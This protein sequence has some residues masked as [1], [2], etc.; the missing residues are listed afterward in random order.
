MIR[1][2]KRKSKIVS[3]VERVY[4]VYDEEENLIDSFSDVSELVKKY[5][6]KS[7]AVMYKSAREN[8][9]FSPDINSM[10]KIKL[11]IEIA[12]DTKL[13]GGRSMII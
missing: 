3:H 5:D 7:P 12:S 2:Q 4:K 11:E 1:H 9:Y 8:S 6:I 10:R 13:T